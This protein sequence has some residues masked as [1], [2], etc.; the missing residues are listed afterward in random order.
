MEK[1]KT[2]VVPFCG[3]IGFDA[4]FCKIALDSFLWTVVGNFGHREREIQF[5][6]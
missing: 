3:Q 2:E 5:E 1:E 4:D 6:K